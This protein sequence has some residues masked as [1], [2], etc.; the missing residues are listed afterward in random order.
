M[1]WYMQEVHSHSHLAP[2]LAQVHKKKKM[3]QRHL[4]AGPNAIPSSKAVAGALALNQPPWRQLPR[5][6]RL[7]AARGFHCTWGD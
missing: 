1:G 4:R 6:C 2:L 3:A 7:N 5:C